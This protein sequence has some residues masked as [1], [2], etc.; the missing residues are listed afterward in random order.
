MLRFDV[1]PHQTRPDYTTRVNY[2]TIKLWHICWQ[3]RAN[4]HLWGDVDAIYQ[5]PN[6]H[7]RD[8]A[9]N[10]QYIVADSV[11]G[12]GVEYFFRITMFKVE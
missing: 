8:D 6:Y 4:V 12:G 11:V 5:M 7:S 1:M 10:D 2:N 9:E 3:P